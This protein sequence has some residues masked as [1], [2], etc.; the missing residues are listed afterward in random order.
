MRYLKRINESLDTTSLSKDEVIDIL[1]NNCKKF[2]NWDKEYTQECLIWRKDINR[3]DFLLVDPKLSPIERIAPYAYKNYHN[4]LISNLDS[5]KGWPRRNK[6][7]ICASSYRALSHAAGFAKEQPVDYAII[8]FDDT[9]I[10]TGDRSDFWNCFPN[11][12][13]DEDFM[14]E[15]LDRPS[16]AYYM[17]SLIN[18]IDRNVKPSH[19]TNWNELKSFLESAEVSDYIINKYFTTNYEVLW[20]DSLNLL[21]NLNILL[22]PKSNNFSLND[23]TKTMNTYSKLDNN[24]S[25]ALESWFEDKAVMIRFDLLGDV[26]KSLNL[27]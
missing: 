18:D 6:S 27:E 15:D 10:A 26:L 14:E 5:W 24:E 21:Q 22:N 7:L 11:L 23:I 4:L 20:D 9:L 16:I 12:P 17:I 1:T 25:E 3:G 13:K 19:N 2:I 8:P